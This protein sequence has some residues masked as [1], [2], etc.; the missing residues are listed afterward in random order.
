M[1]QSEIAQ[2]LVYLNL[3]A[4]IQSEEIGRN[5]PVGNAI[6]TQCKAVSMA[7]RGNRIGAR[8]LSSVHMLKNGY[9]LTR[10]KLQGLRFGRFEFEMPYLRRQ[11]LPAKQ[12]CFQCSTSS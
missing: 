12:S 4:G 2:R 10:R 3:V 6:Q 1:P 7:R 5:Q 11:F 8:D 9:E